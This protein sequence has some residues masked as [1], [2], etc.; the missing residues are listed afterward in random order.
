MTWK[1][2]VRRWPSKTG[3]SRRKREGWQVWCY[4]QLLPV[5]IS[6]SFSVEIAVR[7]SAVYTPQIFTSKVDPRTDRIKPTLVQILVFANP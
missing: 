3:G 6:N 2:E 4:Y 7:G 1:R 5:Y